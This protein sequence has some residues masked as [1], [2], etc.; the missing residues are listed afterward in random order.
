MEYEDV[1]RALGDARA[2]PEYKGRPGPPRDWPLEHIQTTISH[3]FLTERFAYKLKKP[4]ALGYLDYSTL[5]KRLQF[6]RLE[7]DLN[8]RLAPSMYLAVVGV[9]VEDG[10]A[11]MERGKPLEYAVKM[12]RLPADRMMDA[13]LERGEV[14]RAM[15]EALAER[16]AA[17]HSSAATGG[18]VD[19]GGS[20]A[21]IQGNWDENFAQTAPFVDET[22]SRERFAAIRD[23]AYDFMESHR[24]LL[25]ERVR[26]GRIRDCHGDLHSR[27]ICIADDDIYIYDCIEFNQRFR[28]GDVA[29]E[30]AFLAMDLD[31][32]DRPELGSH[33][34][35]R[36]SGLA[37]D[38]E[39]ADLL[40]FYRCYR[41]FVR[42]K[43]LC[44]ELAEREIDSDQRRSD[45]EAARRY[46][47]LAHLYALGPHR[48]LLLVI[49]GM[50][51]SGKSTLAAA[52]R[53]R[54]ATINSDLVRKELAGIAPTERRWEDFGSGIYSREFTD[55]TYAEMMREAER[56]LE[57]GDSVVLDA[58]FASR[59]HRRAA[60]ELAHST[61]AHFFLVECAAP[62][63]VLLARLERKTRDP[64]EISDARPD[65]F[66]RL[67]ES[68][69][70]T[71]EIPFDMR[72]R[73]DTSQ[74]LPDT[75]ASL[76][77]SVP[78]LG[79]GL[80]AGID[81]NGTDPA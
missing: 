11:Y 63:R 7:L 74:P 30:V 36:Y 26:A 2:Y 66:S 28:Y 13:M 27:N 69:E 35:H 52:F 16:V 43:V 41:A 57:G 49:S 55:R 15:V 5:D 19:E 48:P 73:L 12:R 58:T 17:F 67:L 8:R 56:I 62:D 81:P 21:T 68:W 32:N 23:W 72:V 65:L 61:G 45:M 46:F 78:G 44:L 50:T 51:G 47:S 40:D 37:A 64:W 77:R 59:E 60:W 20:L 9:G 71:D 42:G 4:L 31:Y 39:L 75:L 76:R 53:G 54:A 34:A 79:A 33:F 3:V 25:E 6:C 10:R 1:I 14:T 80:S 22:I 38:A 24:D 70:P 29:S 18:E